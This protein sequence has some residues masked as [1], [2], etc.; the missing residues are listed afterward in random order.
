MS[1]ETEV[2]KHFNVVFQHFMTTPEWVAM[3]NTV[4]DSPWHREAN[5]AVHTQMLLD[6]YMKNLSDKRSMRQNLYTLLACM[7]HDVGKPPSEIQK[8]T[9]ERGH[10]RAY[11]GH[12]LVSARMWVD[13]A[14]QHKQMLADLL[15]F[16]IVDI[17]NIALMIEHH[18]P[19][20]IK[21]SRKRESLKNTLMYRLGEDGHRA[22][23]DFLLADQHGR[24][25]DDQEAK[26]KRV[27]IWMTEWEA[28]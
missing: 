4:E 20:D 28:V 5:V 14:I 3:E 22:W 15:S 16:N 1:T 6:W 23:L 13:Y 11:H 12:E 8:F 17:A 24:N 27:N 21:D 26:L 18:V 9:E 19:F 10:Y 2:Y 7:F 25:S